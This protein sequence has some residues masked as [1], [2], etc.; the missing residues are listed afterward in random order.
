MIG[1]GDD[2]SDFAATVEST[3]LP[4]DLLAL[5]GQF[6]ATVLRVGF[7]AFDWHIAASLFLRFLFLV[8]AR[9]DGFVV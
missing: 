7:R 9:R 4:P 8:H 2:V 5:F 3:T 1:K 6:A